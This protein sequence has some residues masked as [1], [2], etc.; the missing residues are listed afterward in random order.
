MPFFS[1]AR[2]N[3]SYIYLVIE[4]HVNSKHCQ[5]VMSKVNYGNLGQNE[6]LF[7]LINYNLK[8]KK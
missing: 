2:K 7:W 3:F 5:R 6:T 4:D 1:K 8:T